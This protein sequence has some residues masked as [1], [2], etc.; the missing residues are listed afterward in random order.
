MGLSDRAVARLQRVANWPDFSG[1]R[2][3]L[4]DQIGRGGMGTVYV[5]HDAELDRDVAVKVT[6]APATHPMLDQRLRTEA[7]A[8]ARLDHPGIV[9]IY[10]VGTL[11]DGRG[12]YTMKLVQGLTLAD[13]L[14]GPVGRGDLLRVFERICETVAAAHVHQ[15][16]HRDLK[17]TNIMV[18]DFGEVFVM[19]WGVA[20]LLGVREA[21]GSSTGDPLPPG[22]TDPGTVLGTPG[23]MPP[24]QAVGDLANV[25]QRS[26]VYALGAILFK[27]LS[28]R[29]PPPPGAGNVSLMLRRRADVPKRLAAVCAKAMA[30]R[31]EDRYQGAAELAAELV[32]F[33][34]GQAVQAYRETVADRVA[35]LAHTHKTAI[36][37]VVAYLVMRIVV[38]LLSR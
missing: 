22:H 36:L 16:I 37:L 7:K 38:A 5:A 32:R 35:R 20:K 9:P 8:L 30:A 15:V 13:Y 21:I 24:E 3:S 18:G 12:F 4:I 33:R 25:D 11:P 10:D 27:L 19:D 29:D 26:D 1:T 6:N 2:Y 34:N 23:F 14:A 17:P 28:G 31:A